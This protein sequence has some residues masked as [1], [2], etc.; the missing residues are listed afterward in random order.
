MSGGHFNYG[1]YHINDIADSIEEYLYGK[2]LYE[3]CDVDEYLKY[4]IDF[5][6]ED[7]AWVREHK[8]TL[9]N[10]HGYSETTIQL[11]EEGL[12]I[13]KK[14]AIYAQRIDWLLSGDD[15][16]ENFKRRLHEELTGLKARAYENNR[17][18]R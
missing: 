18:K 13:L 11:M 8:R 17:T 10:R 3:D 15:G 14:A 4:E 2:E 16:E 12:N 6:E 1:Q 5:S 7:K 9:H